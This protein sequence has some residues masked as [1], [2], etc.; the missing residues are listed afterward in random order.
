MRL[1]DQVSDPC[2]SIELW[3]C[4]SQDRGEVVDQERKYSQHCNVGEPFSYSRPEVCGF[5]ME[6]Y[7]EPGHPHG[8]CLSFVAEYC[9]DNV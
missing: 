8:R 1:A 3:S 9:A 7:R 2:V 5:Q 6:Q 4:A